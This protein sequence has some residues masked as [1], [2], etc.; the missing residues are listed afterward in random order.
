MG[1]ASSHAWE[2]FRVTVVESEFNAQN[3]SPSLSP[4]GFESESRFG[5]D[6]NTNPWRG[7]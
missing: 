5:S 2:I 4:A 6:K 3:S 7:N 1:D